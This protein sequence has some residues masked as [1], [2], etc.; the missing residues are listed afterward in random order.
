MSISGAYL[1]LAGEHRDALNLTPDSSRRARAVEVWSALKSLGRS[2]LAEL[3]SRNCGQARKIA[4]ELKQ[5][6]VE[7]L[8]DVVLNQVVVAFGD[9]D[10]TRRVIV[11]IQ[12]SGK[13]WCGGSTWRGRAVM[14]ISVSSWATTDE[15]VELSVRAI[16]DADRA[17]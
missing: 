4:D 15:D 12:D 7:V 16:L 17:A 8:N 9:D 14:R 10:K 1:P 11:A 13:C 6:G 2:G 3:V 5:A